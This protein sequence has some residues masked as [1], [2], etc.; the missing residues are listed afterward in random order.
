LIVLALYVVLHRVST[1][2]IIA[3]FSFAGK[4]W[5]GS[6]IIEKITLKK[7]ILFSAAINHF[8]SNRCQKGL[9]LIIWFS[10]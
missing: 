9:E 6:E 7:K 8:V 5:T 2:L 4:G 3:S 10:L 1:V